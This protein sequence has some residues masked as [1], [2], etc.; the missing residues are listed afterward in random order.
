MTTVEKIYTTMSSAKRGAIRAKISNPVF[1][2]LADGRISVSEAVMEEVKKVR[3]TK[4]GTTMEI[5]KDLVAKKGGTMG[6]S[7]VIAEAVALGVSYHTARSY[8]QKIYKA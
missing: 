2:K 4:T 1:N 8:Y 6:R 3:K 7:M 5:I